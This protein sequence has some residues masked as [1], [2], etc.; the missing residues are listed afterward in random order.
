STFALNNVTLPFVLSI[1]KNGCRKALMDDPH[2][3]DGLN[4][5]QGHITHQAVAREL[6]KS[7]T[8]PVTLLQK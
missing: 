4:V 2:L 8:D 5:C 6:G 1:A 7:Y 3:R